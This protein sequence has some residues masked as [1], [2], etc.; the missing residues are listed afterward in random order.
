[1]RSETTVLLRALRLCSMGILSRCTWLPRTGKVF[2][3]ALPG[4][5]FMQQRLSAPAKHA[6][7]RPCARYGPAMFGVRPTD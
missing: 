7:K 2:N 4:P 3:D 6:P 1:M 5:S